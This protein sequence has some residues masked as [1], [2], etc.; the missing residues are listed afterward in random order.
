MVLAGSKSL[1]S[2]GSPGMTHILKFITRTLQDLVE[3][4][5]LPFGRYSWIKFFKDI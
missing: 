1:Q 3:Q 4:A 5:P 2:A